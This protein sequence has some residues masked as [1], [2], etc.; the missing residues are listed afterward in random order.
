MVPKALPSMFRVSAP[1]MLT[2]TP[3]SM[4]SEAMSGS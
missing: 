3:Q 4:A 2:F 1:R